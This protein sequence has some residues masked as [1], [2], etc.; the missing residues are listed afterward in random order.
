VFSPEVSGWIASES[1]RLAAPGFANGL[2]LPPYSPDFN[3]AERSAV[4]G[5]LSGAS[6]THT[7]P[8]N[9]QTASLPQDISNL[10]G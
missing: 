4:S 10:I 7:R 2:Y 3:A 5:M 6:S 1:V 8:Q 9:P